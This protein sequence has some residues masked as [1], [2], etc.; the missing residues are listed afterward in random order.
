M[1]N[2]APDSRWAMLAFVLSDPLDLSVRRGVMRAFAMGGRR[3][4]FAPSLLHSQRCMERQ[5]FLWERGGKTMHY[6]F[7]G[8]LT[9]WDCKRWLPFR[10]EVP[11]RC[12]AL[13]I[14]LAFEPARAQGIANRLTLTLF[15]PEGFRGAGHRGG[16]AHHVRITAGEATP[17]YI[18]GPLPIGEWVVE[19]DT[20]MIMPGPFVRYRLDIALTESIGSHVARG[21][22]SQECIDTAAVPEAVAVPDAGW[23][24]GD[25]HTHSHHSDA[26]GL[27]V[28]DMVSLARNYELDFFFLTDHNTNAGLLVGDAR[29]DTDPLIGRGIELT[30]YWGHA[31]CLGTDRWVDWRVRPGRGGMAALAEAAHRA[32]ALFVIAHPLAD[33]DPGC[34]GCAWRFGAMMPGNA[35]LVEVWNGPWDGDSN[36]EDALALW[37]DWL[38]Q[39]LRIVATAGTD[40]H[41][42]VPMG[43][44]P[45]FNV[46][47]AEARSEAALLDALRAGHLYLSAG[48][49]LMLEAEDT[50]GRRAMMGDAIDRRAAFRVVWEGTPEDGE[51]RILVDGRLLTPLA[52][53]SEGEHRWEMAPDAG[54]WVVAEVRDAD[55]KLRAVTNPIFLEREALSSMAPCS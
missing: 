19:I 55:G 32:G 23:Y 11:D 41:G 38:N 20:H 6:H 5:G 33:G 29:C 10:F 28:A 40:V 45:G 53:G 16:A 50:R 36:N 22:K 47:Y 4:R 14:D 2:S 26:K 34:T 35:R 3:L 39:G 9:A 21:A 48:P 46:I 18:P 44:T 51:V 43:V 54:H 31:L 12:D 15:D 24:R 30:T 25:L 49:T 42:K 17:G 13:E 8:E 1:C 7:E 52:S 37:Y 27:T